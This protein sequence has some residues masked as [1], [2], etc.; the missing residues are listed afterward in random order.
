MASFADAVGE[1]QTGGYGDGTRVGV[2]SPSTLFEQFAKMAQ[3]VFDGAALIRRCSREGALQGPGREL[4]D[5]I[6]QVLHGR[7]SDL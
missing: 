3:G 2:G 4:R 6:A 1:M 5:A 7:C